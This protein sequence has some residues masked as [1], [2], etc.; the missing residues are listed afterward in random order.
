MDRGAVDVDSGRDQLRC[1]LLAFG[2]VFVSPKPDPRKRGKVSARVSTVT[3]DIRGFDFRRQSF[4]AS[5]KRRQTM[6]AEGESGIP[7]R[8]E[9]PWVQLWHLVQ[10]DLFAAKEAR[11]VQRGSA[12]VD[13]W[14]QDLL[15]GN[16]VKH[17]PH[18][19]RMP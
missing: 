16:L 14:R 7:T 1:D 3:A 4:E 2:S 5:R 17:Q 6:E 15:L 12:V 9:H 18:D 13:G 10:S 11:E 8:S 19:L